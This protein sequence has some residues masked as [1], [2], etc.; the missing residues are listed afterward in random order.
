VKEFVNIG[1]ILFLFR[2]RNKYDKR[3]QSNKVVN[4]YIVYTVG[5]IIGVRPT[6]N[7]DEQQNTQ[8]QTTLAK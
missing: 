6:H 3:L 5:K 2:N 1:N 8:L 4:G 7:A